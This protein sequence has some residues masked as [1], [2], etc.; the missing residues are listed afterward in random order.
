MTGNRVN[1]I[2]AI[3]GGRHWASSPQGTGKWS[4][5][6]LRLKDIDSNGWFRDTYF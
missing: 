4:R 6:A 5:W 2:L 3:V 1:K